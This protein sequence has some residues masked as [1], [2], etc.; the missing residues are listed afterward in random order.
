M[1]LKQ[2]DSIISRSYQN[3]L[4]SGAPLE[5]LAWGS[6]EPVLQMGAQGSVGRGIQGDHA[7]VFPKGSREKSQSPLEGMVSTTR[8]HVMQIV[9]FNL[10]DVIK[11]SESLEMTTVRIPARVASRGPKGSVL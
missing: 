9:C 4:R 11:C 2:C 10:N 5:S 6:R 7:S 1:F 3:D 8:I